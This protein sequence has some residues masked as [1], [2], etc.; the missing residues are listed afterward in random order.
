MTIRDLIDELENFDE[1]M[2]ICLGMFQNYGSDFVMRIA[3]IEEYGINNWNEEDEHMVV[4]V[5]G[6]QFGTIKA[7]DDE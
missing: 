2:E 3:E 7:E 6:R 4:L 1:D 5:E